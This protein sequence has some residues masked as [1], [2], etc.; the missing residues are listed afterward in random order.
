LDRGNLIRLC[1]TIWLVATVG[2][3]VLYFAVASADYFLF[4][5][6]SIEKDKHYLENQV[7]KE[8]SVAVS[9]IPWMGVLT[10]P[11]FLAEVLGYSKLYDN[12]KPWPQEVASIILYLLFTDCLI[13]WIHRGFHLPWV[14]P[15]IHKTHH[16][17]IVS[18]PFASHAF[19]PLDGWGQSLPY[20]IYV[21]LFPMHKMVYLV[22]FV[23]VNIWTISIHDR[24][25]LS[26]NKIINGSDHHVLHHSKFYY[27]YGQYFTIWDRI[28]GT[29][30]LPIVNADKIV[31]NS[32]D[33]EKVMQTAVKITR[34]K[35][36][37]QKK[38]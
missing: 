7:A 36:P 1:L 17:W 4:F 18:T 10:T 19:S 22:L 21:L 5:D 25:F 16:R 12:L 13:Y 27:N 6:K 24:I 35:S 11:F 2:A 34:T 3:Y 38:L 31:E 26:R 33:D 28:C 30:Q 20:H 32:F 29:H 9:S 15:Y 14:Y 37:S 8:I 23:L